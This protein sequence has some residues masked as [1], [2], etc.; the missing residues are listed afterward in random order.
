[1]TYTWI[2]YHTLSTVKHVFLRNLEAFAAESPEN[3]EDIHPDYLVSISISCT[4]DLIDIISN[5][6]I[7]INVT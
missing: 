1:M 3:I 7:L 2:H 4:N 5:T 6:Q